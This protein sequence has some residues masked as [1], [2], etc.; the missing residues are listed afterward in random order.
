[1]INTMLKFAIVLENSIAM[2][3]VCLGDPANLVN[4]APDRKTRTSFLVNMLPMCQPKLLVLAVMF[5]SK[6]I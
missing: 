5:S 6:L 1:M 4:F 2:L 3:T